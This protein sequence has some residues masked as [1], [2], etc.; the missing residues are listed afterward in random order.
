MKTTL[1]G[2]YHK[3][4]Y[5][6]NTR[7]YGDVHLTFGEAIEYILPVR[8]NALT[9]RG[10]QRVIHE[11]HGKT[12]RKAMR[13]GTYTPTQLS[14]GLRPNHRSGLKVDV[15][16][17]TFTLE[18]DSEDP[19][20]QTD[21]GH[22]YHAIE[23]E[24][25]ETRK[26]IEACQDDAMRKELEGILTSLLALPLGFRIYFDGDLKS[27]FI[28]LQSGRSVD[29]AHLY[30]LKIQQKVL[31]APE[32]KISFEVCRH[33]NK[34]TRS[35]FHNLLRFDSASAANAL[36]RQMPISTLSAKGSSDLSTST[37]GLAR[38][39]LARKSDIKPEALSDFVV[40]SYEAIHKGHFSALEEGKVLT[41]PRFSGTKGSATMLVGVGLCL[42]YRCLSRENHAIT[43]DDLELVVE[44]VKA[45]LDRPV[46]GNLSGQV[47]RQLMGT[48][49]EAFLDDLDEEK[50]DGLPIGLLEVLSPSAFNAAS[51]PKKKK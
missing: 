42:A 36:V 19:I 33:L 22:R 47:K 21:G 29:P 23:C 13:E 34:H 25:K 1:S 35:P 10:E 11:G 18:V 43:D 37:I 28:A 15:K 50:H 46:E 5:L 39:A 7:E 49:A 41:P 26:A 6:G 44:C 9:G 17:G 38:I 32:F 48:Y 40:A 27:D 3:W 31:S 24:V 20:P 30:S 2:T 8:Y 51:L 12:L 45:L 16:N 14:A 4:D